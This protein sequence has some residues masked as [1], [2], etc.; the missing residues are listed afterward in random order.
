MLVIASHF[1][2][3]FMTTSKSE[4]YPSGVLTYTPLKQFSHGFEHKYQATLDICVIDKWSSLQFYTNNSNWLKFFMV[5]PPISAILI[6]GN[7]F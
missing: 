2:P 5:Q 6:A 4:A 3:G 1:R 7:L